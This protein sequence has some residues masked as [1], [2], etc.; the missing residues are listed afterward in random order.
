M[1]KGCYQEFAEKKGA[2]E[3]FKTILAG[4]REHARVLL[5]W[6]ETVSPY[7]EGLTQEINPEI[8]EVYKK[9]IRL[10]KT[11]KSLVYGSFEVLDCKKDRFT[12]R[13]RWKNEEFIIDC[14]L[15]KK[16]QK[17]YISRGDY[18]LIYGSEEE[19]G[20]VLKSYEARIWCKARG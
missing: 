16:K 4:T 7:H 18:L 10:R 19:D 15:G 17:A 20:T 3:A 2:E 13:R 12:Y 5:P 6:N 9:L 14:N 8:T 11:C 1:A